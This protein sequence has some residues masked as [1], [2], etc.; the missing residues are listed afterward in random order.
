M[1]TRQMLDSWKIRVEI[2]QNEECGYA[3]YHLGVKSGP[4]KNGKEIEKKI[5]V[6]KI[7]GKH[8][9]AK[10]LDYY[11][12]GFSTDAKHYSITLQRLVY[13]YFKGDIPDGYE[14]DHIN[15]DRLDNSLDNLRCLTVKENRQNKR[16]QCNQWS[17]IKNDKI[18][19]EAYDIEQKVNKILKEVKNNK[20]ERMKALRNAYVDGLITADT[21][22]DLLGEV[23]NVK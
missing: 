10:D 11:A 6:K 13:A 21:Y 23:L 1:L 5:K 17:Y 18:L 12:V 2:D 7:Y 3:I 22:F 14:I 8:K 4:K 15:A 19:R 20:I 16:T 9:Y